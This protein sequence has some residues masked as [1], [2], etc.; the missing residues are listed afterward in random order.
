MKPNQRR[1]AFSLI[2]MLM[3]ISIGSTL[4]LTSVALLHKSLQLQKRSQ[5]R[6]ERAHTLNH[7]VEAFRRDV[8]AASSAECTSES[9]LTLS[10]SSGDSIAYS[11]QGN[12][13][14][15]TH[16]DELGR[17]VEQV[18]IAEHES[19]SFQLQSDGQI[20]AFEIQGSPEPNATRVMRQI[21]VSLRAWSTP[22]P[23]AEITKLEETP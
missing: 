23:V 17:Q 8:H 2:E 16:V 10:L 6:M 22:Q 13:L 7:F 19:A 20:V 4:M 15:R 11:S 1:K 21:A 12:R 9:S 3:T 14:T 18:E 5:G